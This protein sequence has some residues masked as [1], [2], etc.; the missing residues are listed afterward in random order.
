MCLRLLLRQQVVVEVFGPSQPAT[1]SYHAAD[2]MIM[3]YELFLL[4]F[5]TN[6]T[7]NKYLLCHL[8][9]LFD[10]NPEITRH[11]N[12]CRIRTALIANVNM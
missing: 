4:L 7:V 1:W 10:Q 8:K 3:I 12:Y 6:N 9:N 5:F 2:F 11:A